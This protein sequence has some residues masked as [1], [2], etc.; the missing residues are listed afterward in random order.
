MLNILDAFSRESLAIRINRKLNST[1][2]IDALTDLFILRGVPGHIRSDNGPEFIAKAVRD[3]IAA[4]G[5]TTAFIEPGSPW[6]N[7]YCESFNAR[8][9]DEFVNG[10][11]FYSLG[12]A[13]VVIDSWRRHYNPERPH[14]S[15]GYKPPAPE[16]LLWPEPLNGKAA[17]AKPTVAQRPTLHQDL[18]RTTLWGQTS[19][20]NRPIRENAHGSEK[21][22]TIC[23][24]RTHI[25]ILVAPAHSQP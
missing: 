2:V 22:L 8:L 14:S 9:G 12:E 13:K 18:H 19:R 15:L 3:W 24:E 11:I 6:E 20:P 4:V 21:S 5:A 17:T 23:R 16:V 25:C 7:G 1:D 10:E